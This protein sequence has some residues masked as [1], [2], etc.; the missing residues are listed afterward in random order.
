VGRFCRRVLGFLFAIGAFEV[1]EQDQNHGARPAAPKL[2]ARLVFNFSR[3]IFEGV[4]CKIVDIT[5]NNLVP[6][7]ADVKRFV[8]ESGGRK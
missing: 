4:L 6:I 1:A 8:P 5:A 3:I 7:L 2:G